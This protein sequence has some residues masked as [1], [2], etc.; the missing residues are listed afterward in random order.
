M[1]EAKEHKLEADMH[2]ATMLNLEATKAVYISSFVAWFFFPSGQINDSSVL[3]IIY[4][5]KQLFKSHQRQ[6]QQQHI[7]LKLRLFKKCSEYL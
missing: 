6:R 3:L 5:Y 2:K 1:L 4:C 7:Q